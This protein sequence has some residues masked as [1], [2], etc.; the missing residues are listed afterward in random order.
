[1]N[2]ES[3]NLGKNLLNSEMTIEMHDKQWQK[4]GINMVNK[5]HLAQQSRKKIT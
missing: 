2:G 4:A 1:M 5:E 3:K